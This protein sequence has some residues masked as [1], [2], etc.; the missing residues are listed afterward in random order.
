LAKGYSKYSQLNTEVL[1]ISQAGIEELGQLQRELDLPFP[2]LS[3][4]DGKVFGAYLGQVGSGLPK[5]AVFIA[6]R[7]GALYTST[8]AADA[9]ELPSEREI[10]DWLWF[11]EIQ[12]PECFPPEWP[13]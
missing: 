11:I 9:G 5:T 4:I 6:D 3:D 10:R 8:I 1:A 13:Q 2:L 7:Y 12:C